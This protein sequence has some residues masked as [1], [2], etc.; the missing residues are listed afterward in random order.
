MKRRERVF[1]TQWTVPETPPDPQEELYWEM[2]GYF[3]RDRWD[4]GTKAWRKKQHRKDDPHWKPL[5]ED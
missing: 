5:P 1:Q 3:F 2:K 4:A